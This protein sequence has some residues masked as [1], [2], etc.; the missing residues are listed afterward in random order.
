MPASHERVPNKS[1]SGTEL[2]QIILND[3]KNMLDRDGMFGNNLAF[4]RVAYEV[5]VSMHLDNPSYPEH[6][7]TTVSRP[8]SKQQIEKQ[9]ELAAIEIG[10]LVEPVTD[11]EAITS[12]ERQ[13]QINSPNMARIENDMPL[14]IS[15]RDMDTGRPIEVQQKFTGDMPDPAEVGN[16]SAD[17]NKSEEQRDKWGRPKKVGKK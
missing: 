12:E 8:H 6:V 9:P 11:E 5:R 16:V 3:V 17:S 15:K 14:T 7:S 1:L 4:A 2:K 13:R 10:P